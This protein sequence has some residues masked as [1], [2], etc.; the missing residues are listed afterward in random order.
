MRTR[1]INQNPGRV[2]IY[3]WCS[4]HNVSQLRITRR[5]LGKIGIIGVPRLPGVGKWPI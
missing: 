2:N 3:R 5:Y 1:V 4:K